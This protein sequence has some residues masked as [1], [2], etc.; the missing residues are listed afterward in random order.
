MK[1]ITSIAYPWRAILSCHAGESFG[2]SNGNHGLKLGEGA[3]PDSLFPRS[4]LAVAQFTHRG[5]R[6]N[7]L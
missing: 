6:N 1:T 5:K 2:K 3:S 7:F 4:D